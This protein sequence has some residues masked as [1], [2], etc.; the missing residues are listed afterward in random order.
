PTHQIFQGRVDRVRIAGR[1]LILKQIPLRIAIL[2]VETDPIDLDLQNLENGFSKALQQP[3]QAGIRVMLTEEDLT[4]SLL[5]ASDSDDTELT[6]GNYTL[7]HPQIDFLESNRLRIQVEIQD[8][9]DPQTVNVV[10]ESGLEVREGR[11]IVFVDPVVRANEETVPPQLLD[12]IFGGVDR[13]F[14]LDRFTPPGTIVRL[15]ELHLTPD[16]IEV[17]AFVRIEHENTD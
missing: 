13:I 10:V 15:L 9:N 14:D 1:G 2:E 4:R 16:G 6:I 3:L 12:A 5:S 17:A 8:G 11:H 7:L